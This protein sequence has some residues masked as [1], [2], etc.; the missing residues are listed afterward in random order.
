MRKYFLTMLVLL[1][2]A[3]GIGAQASNDNMLRLA[4]SGT[5]TP[6]ETEHSLLGTRITFS[7]DG[8]QMNFTT[9]EATVVY[10]MGL[11]SGMSHHSGTPTV[12][13]TTHENPADPGYYYTTFYSGLEAYAIPDGVTAYTASL[14]TYGT[15]TWL[16]LSEVTGGVLPQGEAVLLKTTGTAIT[17]EAT[18][19]TSATA[20]DTNVLDGVDV[21]T[22][23]TS[24]GTVYT[25]AGVD[26][27]MG[28]YQYIGDQMPA[29]K[30]YL[31]LPAGTPA[32]RRIAF[33]SHV[34]TGVESTECKVQSAK[35]IRDGQL[36][37]ERDTRTYNAQ[38]L[39]V[40]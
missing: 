22:A 3:A 31:T 40:Y 1:T 13:L 37:I 30:A 8:R 24:L 18:D 19:P 34:T 7:E 25:L 28:F 26:G 27:V 17:M 14:A 5:G 39:I 6:V 9:N 15:E 16:N 12:S 32:P 29:N 36:Y 10:D 20:D 21:A 35:Y 4:F 2:Y 33:G 11:V 23:T 38:G